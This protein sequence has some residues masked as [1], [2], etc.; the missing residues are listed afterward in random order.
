MQQFFVTLIDDADA[1]VKRYFA[2]LGEVA[3]VAARVGSAIYFHRLW[4]ADTD[5]SAL[6]ASV[7]EVKAQYSVVIS[8]MLAGLDSE[9][10][11]MLSW[12]IRIQYADNCFAAD[13]ALPMPAELFCDSED[14]WEY[15]RDKSGFPGNDSVVSHLL[16]CSACDHFV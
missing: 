11:R 6:L 9:G 13:E 7:D 12:F 1:R 2:A 3:R 15:L 5:A 4:M 16:T 8:T 14:P 10:K